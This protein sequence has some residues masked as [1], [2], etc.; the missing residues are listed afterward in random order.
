MNLELYVEKRL[1]ESRLDLWV[2][3]EEMSWAIQDY[4][5]SYEPTGRDILY[6]HKLHYCLADFGE[7]SIFTI[8]DELA[9]IE[10]D[11]AEQIDSII[12]WVGYMNVALPLYF[13]LNICREYRADIRNVIFK[14]NTVDKPWS[15]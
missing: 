8:A 1:E 13:L 4:L 14:Q 9:N 15:I 7:D 6:L 11:T 5:S 2:S 10:I 12:K 3:D